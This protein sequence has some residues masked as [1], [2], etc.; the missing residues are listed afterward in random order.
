ML[1]ILNLFGRSPFTPLRNHMEKVA[2]CIYKLEE[3]FGAIEE[4][5]YTEAEALA[6]EI[7]RLEHEADLTKNSIR[8]NLP[9]SIF[10][11]IDRACLLDILSLQD[12]IADAVEDIAIVATLKPLEILDSFQAEFRDFLKNNLKAFDG[13]LAIIEE[14][15]ELLESSFGGIEAEKVRKIVDEVAYIEH[16]VDLIQRELTKKL[17]QAENELTYSSYYIWMKL[18]ELIASL[19]NISEKLAYRVRTTLDIKTK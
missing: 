19:S 9:R 1:T 5:D 2:A 3:L 13:A 11:P 17:I 8:N 18:F 10:L 14:F 16:E 7:S 12:A 15:Q 6:K 4:K